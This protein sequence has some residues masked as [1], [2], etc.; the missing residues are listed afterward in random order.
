MLTDE[1]NGLV[2]DTAGVAEANATENE[3]VEPRGPKIQE[4][5]D[6]VAQPTM[7]DQEQSHKEDLKEIV[8]HQIIW[9][10]IGLVRHITFITYL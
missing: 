7:P 9:D 6:P 3:D 8:S 2:A 5:P 4:Q 10:T 1:E